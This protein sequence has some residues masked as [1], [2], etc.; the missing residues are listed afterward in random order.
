MKKLKSIILIQYHPPQ[1]TSYQKMAHPL[2][3]SLLCRLPCHQPQ[4]TNS[5]QPS[6]AID[7][8]TLSN[9]QLKAA[10]ALYAKQ[11]QAS[12]SR[13][14][15]EKRQAIAKENIANITQF[16]QSHTPASNRTIA[17][18]LNLPPRRVQHYMQ[19]LTH[20]GSVRAEGWGASRQY[21]KA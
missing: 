10:A 9:E 7:I 4:T 15:V 19:I 5:Q 2:K 6:P 13:K 16:I 14:G 3:N 12:L 1:T 21:F 8:S 17:R 18:A 11:N 20:N